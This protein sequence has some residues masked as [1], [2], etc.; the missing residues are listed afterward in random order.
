MHS[1]T[2]SEHELILVVV[3]KISSTKLA[4][5]ALVLLGSPALL[6]SIA[7]AI[8]TET[9]IARMSSCAPLLAYVLL[10]DL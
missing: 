10:N 6:L 4:L 3:L 1:C 9:S 5:S 2:L 7:T 8:I